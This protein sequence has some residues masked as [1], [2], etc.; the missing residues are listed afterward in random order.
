M[1]DSRG[2]RI[3]T[4][5]GLWLTV[6]SVLILLLL[7][8]TVAILPDATQALLCCGPFVPVGI[9]AAAAGAVTRRVVIADADGVLSS[10]EPFGITTLDVP[11]S[12]IA[13][14]TMEEVER[15][16]LDIQEFWV[17]ISSVT[18]FRV[19]LVLTDHSERQVAGHLDKRR[20]KRIVDA[21]RAGL[22]LP[23][24]QPLTGW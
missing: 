1:T 15:S 6:T 16:F 2:T 4:A 24:D 3:V 13:Y 22:R 12:D 9:V 8:M 20:A 18:S 5:S 14:V 7:G 17:G 11:R 23:G 21:I 19:R 10:W